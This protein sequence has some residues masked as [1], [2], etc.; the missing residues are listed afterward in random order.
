VSPYPAESY[1][2]T[3]CKFVYAVAVL[4]NVESAFNGGSLKITPAIIGLL[5]LAF[6]GTSLSADAV[7]PWFN[8]R[9]YDAGSLSTPSGA[10]TGASDE[11]RADPDDSL[12]KWKR[13]H[14]VDSREN[15][16]E[17]ATI[18]LVSAALAGLAA[19]RFRARKPGGSHD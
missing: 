15:A 6:C 5:L 10:V 9:S 11:N 8:G 2:V 13:E 17:P 4:R 7:D 19:Y 14:K 12:L 16:P 1:G 18:L 3:E